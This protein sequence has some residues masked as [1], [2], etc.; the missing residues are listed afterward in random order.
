MWKHALTAKT[1]LS[2]Q[3]PESERAGR[4]PCA[5][6]SRHPPGLGNIRLPQPSQVHACSFPAG[7][8]ILNNY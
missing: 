6:Q 5:E 3:A 8:K 1:M 7:W 2:R 4:K